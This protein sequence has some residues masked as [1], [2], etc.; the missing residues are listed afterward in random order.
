MGVQAG[1]LNSF[2]P[3]R[4]ERNKSYE[5]YRYPK[6]FPVSYP[7]CAAGLCFNIEAQ[8]IRFYRNMP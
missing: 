8:G 6:K 5:A 1:T 2:I 4:G 3:V 7:P